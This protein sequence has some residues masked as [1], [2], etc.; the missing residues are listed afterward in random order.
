MTSV[1]VKTGSATGWTAKLAGRNRGRF[2]NMMAW[3]SVL[4]EQDDC[5]EQL[6]VTFYLT[7]IK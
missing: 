6:G 4:G 5:R 3:T 7:A 1:N 2:R